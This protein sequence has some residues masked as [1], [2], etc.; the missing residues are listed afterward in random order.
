MR[1]STSPQLLNLSLITEFEKAPNRR[2]ICHGGLRQWN[3][4][5]HHVWNRK[6]IVKYHTLRINY[7]INPNLIDSI[8]RALYFQCGIL[9]IN[10]VNNPIAEDLN[11]RVAGTI[12]TK[13]HGLEADGTYNIDEDLDGTTDYS[14]DNPNFSY[15]QFRSNLQCVGNTS[16]ALRYFGLVPGH[17][18]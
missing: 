11:E 5:L 18:A 4:S 7:N 6:W 12:T 17:W 10:Y 13:F 16:R 3:P 2:N 15:V 8:L 9:Q 14:F 1:F